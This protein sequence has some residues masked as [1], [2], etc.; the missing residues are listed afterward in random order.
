MLRC[1]IGPKNSGYKAPARWRSAH[2]MVRGIDLTSEIL[3]GQGVNPKPGISETREIH[4]I[5][6]R[7]LREF[8]PKDPFSH[9]R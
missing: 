2:D 8:A 6:W 4:E 1:N 7:M 5:D 9:G 3:P